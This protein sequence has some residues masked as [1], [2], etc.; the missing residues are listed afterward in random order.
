MT[1]LKTLTDMMNDD[2]VLKELVDKVVMDAYISGMEKGAKELEAKQSYIDGLEKEI[3]R[4]QKR[5]LNK[6][7]YIL[8]LGNQI[9]NCGI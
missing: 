4:L 6:D 9:C 5:I 1:K 8:E 3:G 2:S 7:E